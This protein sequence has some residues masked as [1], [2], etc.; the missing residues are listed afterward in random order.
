MTLW[1]KQPNNEQAGIQL[2]YEAKN[3]V[4]F[5]V[6]RYQRNFQK[7]SKIIVKS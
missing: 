1:H 5:K 7:I 2:K 3:M 4:L 6:I